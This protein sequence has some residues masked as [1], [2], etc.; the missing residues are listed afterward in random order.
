MSQKKLLKNELNKFLEQHELEEYSVNTL[1]QYKT[2][3]TKFID[4]I[5]N[6]KEITKR[7]MIRYKEHLDSISS[8][9]GSKNN[10][11]V[12]RNMLLKNY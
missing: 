8:S 12:I 10:W 7:D 3:V 9:T 2:G 4:F 6:K 11:I 1:K 5:G